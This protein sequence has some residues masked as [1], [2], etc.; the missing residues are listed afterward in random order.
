MRLRCFQDLQDGKDLA[1]S[2]SD[3]YLK[4][5]S[6]EFYSNEIA[7]CV[8]NVDKERNACALKE[9]ARV[10]KTIHA[11]NCKNKKMDVQSNLHLQLTM[12]HCFLLSNSK[13]HFS[14]ATLL[15]I[16][17]LLKCKFCHI[18]FTFS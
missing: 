13:I 3:T 4:S 8:L 11:I 10:P 1:I 14:K 15:R 2:E 16:I 9:R 12:I 7:I 6:K 5:A 17:F 18:V